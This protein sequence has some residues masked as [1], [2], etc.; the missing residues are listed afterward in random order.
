MYVMEVIFLHGTRHKTL[1]WFDTKEQCEAER[2]KLSPYIGDMY[3]NDKKVV[4]IHDKFGNAD[5]AVMHVAA[6]LC[7]DEEARAEEQ[8]IKSKRNLELH[9]EERKRLQEAGVDQVR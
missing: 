1:S 9:I 5:I 3:R 6:V 8:K 2:N 4:T 7:W